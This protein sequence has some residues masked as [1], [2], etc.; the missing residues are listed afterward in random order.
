[1]KNKEISAKKYISQKIYI[2]NSVLILC[3]IGF[4]F[5][6]SYFKV[7]ILFYV[8]LV[9]ITLCLLA[10]I[11]L[12]QHKIKQYALIAFIELYIFMISFSSS[13]IFFIEEY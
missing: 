3:H 5:I 12:K 1:M 6:F 2:V 7:N 4:S 8:N 13:K 11:C 10:F 9:N